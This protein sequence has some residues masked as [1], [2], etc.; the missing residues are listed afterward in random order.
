M[1]R[2]EGGKG[3]LILFSLQPELPSGSSET[4]LSVRVGGKAWGD[5][6]SGGLW[7]SPPHPTSSNLSTPNA[8]YR[9]SHRFLLRNISPLK[10]K[11][12]VLEHCVRL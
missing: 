6:M 7:I 2:R 8:K 11:I 3:L 1:P 12:N 4:I 5:T 9:F 10:K